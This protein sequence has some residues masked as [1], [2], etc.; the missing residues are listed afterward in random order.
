MDGPWGHYGNWNKPD[1]ERQILYHLTWVE[2]KQTY[3]QTHGYKQTGDSQ[4]GVGGGQNGWRESKGNLPVIKYI[5][6]SPGAVIYSM[7]T[8][9]RH[10]GDHFTIYINIE[11]LCCTPETRKCDMSIISQ[12]NQTKPNPKPDR[13]ASTATLVFFLVALCR[14]QDLGSPTRDWTWA[15]TVKASSINHWTAREFLSAATF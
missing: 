1:K 8:I 5:Y 11:S 13:G 6:I 3:K 15:T 7:V 12:K 4:A 9:T 10:C 2:S 14:L